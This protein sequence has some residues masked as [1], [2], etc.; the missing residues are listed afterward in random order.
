MTATEAR[1]LP[2]AAGHAP[3]SVL[4]RTGRGIRTM[5]ACSCEWV[6]ANAPASMRS[7]HN[8]HMAHRRSKG[9]P[10]FDYSQVVFGEGPWTGWTWDEW[11]AKHGSKNIDPY[12]G[13]VREW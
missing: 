1:P 10:R 7:M 3:L 5:D 12:T 13:Q 9:L 11:Y 8:A 4:N 2:P 6:A